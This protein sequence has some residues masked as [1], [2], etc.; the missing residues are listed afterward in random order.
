M[1]A[2]TAVVTAADGVVREFPCDLLLE[3]KAIL[4]EQVGGEAIGGVMG[5][6]NQ[7]WIPGLP[8]KYFV[9]DVV[10]IRLEER[11]WPPHIDLEGF[12]DDGNQYLNRPNVSVGAYYSCHAGQTAV[13]EGTASDYAAPS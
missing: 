3:R 4:V 11:D 9:R 2:N 8:A 1:A 12:V 6:A 13:F 10:S 7:L 5:G